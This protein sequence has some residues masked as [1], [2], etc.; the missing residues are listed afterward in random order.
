MA[1]PKGNE[2][3]LVKYKPKWRSGKTRTIRVPIAISDLVLEAAREIDV[4]GNKSLVS[5]IKELKE[6]IKR[7]EASSTVT[8]DSSR[9]KEN[10]KQPHSKDGDSS[11][12][13]SETEIFTNKDVAEVFGVHPSTIGK[14][15]KGEHPN[16]SIR[17]PLFKNYQPIE[18]DGRPRWI[19]RSNTDTSD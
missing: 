11:T 3:S 7:L 16:S 6:K 15:R 1:N 13:T 17:S 18:V 9:N 5:V 4:N 10:S 2:A 14:I 12:D 8:S 19:K